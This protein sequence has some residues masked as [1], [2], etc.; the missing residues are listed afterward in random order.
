MKKTVKKKAAVKK[1]AVKKKASVK[2]VAVKKKAVATAATPAVKKL[3]TAKQAY[4]KS[5]LLMTLSE[6]TGVSK[7]EVGA[8]VD[9]LADVINVHIKKGA[10]GQF[11]MPGLFKVR[12]VRKKAT[13]AR[14]GVNPFTGEETVFK[15]KPARTV[16]K[17]MPLKKMKDMVE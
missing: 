5:Q 3:T 7:K 16:L 13:R 6:Q 15:A 12:T 1:S 9:A 11:T 17:L 14:K 4:T 10:V 8:V 2:K